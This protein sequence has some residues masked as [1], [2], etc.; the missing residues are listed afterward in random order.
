M[1]YYLHHITEQEILWKMYPDKEKSVC[2]LKQYFGHHNK[3]SDYHYCYK[4][5]IV[6]K[7]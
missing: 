1:T 7:N 4:Q 6:K 5:E 2:I 3:N